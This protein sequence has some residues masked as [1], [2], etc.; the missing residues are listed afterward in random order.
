MPE[1]SNGENYPSDGICMA[2]AVV[3]ITKG[4]IEGNEKLGRVRFGDAG[5]EMLEITTIR[6]SSDLAN[7]TAEKTWKQ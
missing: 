3:Q 6:E 2:E 5:L 1:K 4:G 7:I